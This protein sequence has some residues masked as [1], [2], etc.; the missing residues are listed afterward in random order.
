M[1]C[2]EIG[3]TAEVEDGREKV[4]NRSKTEEAATS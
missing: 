4:G 3:S 1:M 2:P